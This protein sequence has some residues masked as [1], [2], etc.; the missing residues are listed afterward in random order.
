VRAPAVL[1]VALA[2]SALIGAGAGT[3]ISSATQERPAAPSDGPALA[4]VRDPAWSADGRWLAISL[5]DRLHLVSAQ[6]QVGPPIALWDGAGDRAVVERD[7]SWSADG[8]RIVFA[9]DRGAGFDLYVVAAQGGRPQRLTLLPGDERWPTWSRDGRIVFAARDATQWDLHVLDPDAGPAGTPP[10]VRRLTSDPSDERDPSISPD[11]RWLA[12]VSTRDTEDGETDLWLAAFPSRAELERS[13]EAPLV[14]STRRLVWARGLEHRPAW[15]RDGRQVAFGAVR[16]GVGSVW[17]ASAETGAEDDAGPTR[18]VAPPRLVSRHYGTACWSA[19]GATLLVAVLPDPDTGYNGD[20][21]RQPAEPPPAFAPP[22]VY[23]LISLPAPV[24][25]DA[26][27]TAFALRAPSATPRWAAMFDRTW[28]VLRDLYYASGPAADE[29]RRLGDRFRP[30]AARAADAAE[31]ERRVDDL[32]A[33]Q[34]LVK[35]PVS[36]RGAVVVTGHRLASEAGARTIERGGNVVDAA[37]AASF[38]LGVVEPDASGIGGDGMAILWLTSM[39]V[40]VVVDFKDQTP[41]RATLD[42]PRIFRGGRL[43]TDG[44]AAVN[45]PGLVAGLQLLH[46]RYGSGRI[47]WADLVS[48]AA[49]LAEDGFVLDAS[50]P[51]TIVEGRA[52]IGRY[53]EAA[54]VL[55]PGGRA[56]RAGERF[57]NPDLA[58]TLRTLASEGA[59]SFYRGSIARRI[60][61]DLS[62]NAGL[63]TLEDLAQYRAIERVPLSGRF[64][65]H[66]VYSAPPPVSA[67]ASLIEALQVMDRYRSAARPRVV[68][69]PDYLHYLI[70]A[71]K[72]REPFRRVADPALWPVDLGDRLGAAHADAVFAAIDPSHAGTFPGARPRDAEPD[73]DQA[74]ERI[75]RGTTALVVAD[76]AGNMIAV[77]QTLSTWGGSFYVSQGLGFLYNN[78]LR[79]YR[80]TPGAY[81]QLLPLMRSSS[82]AVP[83]LIFDEREAV[84]RPAIAIA[85]AGNAWITASVYGMLAEMIAG[86]VPPQDAIEAPRF[87]V[88]RDPADA[89]GARAVVQIEDRFPRRVLDAL[90]ARGHVFRK[91]GR[92]GEL[93]FGYAAAARVDPASGRV[94]AATEPRRSH[95]AVAVPR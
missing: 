30:L 91:V 61:E 67:G 3:L 88:A 64:R 5:Y 74:D 46:E 15:S 18:P 95:A 73:A 57:V 85:S 4:G 70:E 22:P 87:L 94:E 53:A 63:I 62:A 38:A 8:A 14:G 50:L 28:G 21:R 37:V 36:S 20:P 29:W 49:A 26:G 54:R 23:T 69:D 71:W 32:I 66:T 35:A 40:P 45:I 24:P 56:P 34:P 44:P 47:R 51:T 48:P 55:M 75:G 60:A 81:G 16:D 17:V 84:R 92:K 43:V 10:A 1:R 52:Q 79:G 9:A 82:T 65:G 31:F 6:R 72:L 12:F 89:T 76:A 19:D 39:D 25:P 42:N 11:G 80:T 7:P 33:A 59:G 77:T 90:E 27:S 41:M 13:D 68:S 93:K 2:C 86:E 83:T 58:A 78:H